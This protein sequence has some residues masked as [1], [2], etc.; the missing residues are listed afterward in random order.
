MNTPLRRFIGLLA[1]GALLTA[2][3]PAALAA[4][5][6]RAGPYRVELTTEPP[7]IPV[8][9]ARLTLKITD[10][11]GKPVEGAQVRA[12][13]QMPGMPMGEQ[14]G[15]A[16]PQP[17]Q[18]GVYSMAASFSM[19]GAYTATIKITGPQGPAVAQIPLKTGQNTAAPAGGGFSPIALLPWI[20]G[21]GAVGFILYRVW[22]TRPEGAGRPNWRA[23]FNRQVLGGLALVAVMLAGAFFA[24]RQ[25]RRPGS[26][27]P[28]EAQGME[29]STPAPPGT[30][31]VELATV[32]RGPVE[33]T[34]R[35]TGQ[36][37][38]F[39]EQDVTPRVRGYI[40]W[41][42]S[43]AGDRVKRGQVL[44]RLD[45]SEVAPVVAERQAGVAI[46]QQ[47]AGVA[48]TEYQQALGA[49]SQAKAELGTRQGALTETRSQETRTSGVLREAQTDLRTAEGALA[50]AQGD[51]AAAREERAGAE[52]DVAAAQTQVADAESQLQAAEAD[53]QYW[54]VQLG[55]TRVLLAEGAVSDEEYR[56]EK[57]QAENADAKVR[58]AQARISQVQSQVRGAQARLRKAG[59]MISSASAKERQANARIDGSRAR[60]EQAQAD[61]ASAAARIEQAQADLQAHHAH[62]RQAQSAANAARQRIGQAQSA[63]RQAQ[64]SL[65]GAA[66]A[67]GYTAVHS[68]L[69][70][71]VTQR[72]VS[73]GQLVNPGQTL[74]RVAQ[75]SPIRLQANVADADLG[76]VR[77]GTPVTIRKQA[78]G[79]SPVSARVTS[80][81]PAVDPAAR[82]GLVEAVVP[83]RDGRF[84]PGEYVVMD[85]ATGRS[86]S[87]LYVPAR[88]IRWRTAPSAGVLST[89]SSPYVWAA[90]S[91][92]GQQNQYTARQVDVRVGLS[93]GASTEVTSGLQAGQQVVINGQ[94]TLKNG[95]TVV[96]VN[97]E[98][99]RPRG[100]TGQ[101]PSPAPSAQLY[102]C[103]MHPEVVQDRPGNCPKCGMA[104][105][106]KPAP[107][108]GGTPSVPGSEP[109][110]APPAGTPPAGSGAGAAPGPITPGLPPAA[111][112][113]KMSAR[114]GMP[115]G[116][117]S[118]MAAGSGARTGGMTP[119]SA[120]GG[121][122]RRMPGAGATPG[123]SPRTGRSGMDGGE[124][125]GS[126]M[127]RSGARRGAAGMGSGSGADM[128]SGGGVP[129]LPPRG[130][131]PRTP[132]PGAMPAPRS[133]NAGPGP[134]GMDGSRPASPS[135]GRTAGGMTG[136]GR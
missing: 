81:A 58:Q 127:P 102:T 96:A 132:P 136:M 30:A 122:M 87:T 21:L 88:A 103:P 13:A 19:A 39:L 43:Y 108:G 90:E 124:A 35:Y 5:Q 78:G 46:A 57:A 125:S 112:R 84:V 48:R 133:T 64:A 77:V 126:G 70:G 128:P 98:A 71:V 12:I 6:A 49:V 50:E 55:R 52:A 29:M 74:L 83:N 47:G 109:G 95:D 123:M 118:G 115:V 73:P 86:A 67:E 119:G 66:T 28:I 53:R 60:I 63:V 61:I 24:V 44:A 89:Q 72:V 129:G 25:F 94:D 68:Q 107:S 20:A 7:V 26:M 117:E 97:A 130:G 4:V 135:K 121:G 2:P 113:P 93:N 104:L 120:P 131:V 101:P 79:Q 54:T 111:A 110:E 16:L 82:T 106:P 91:I 22:R 92:E 14:E 80:I 69:D 23:V 114:P 10:A 33:S 76:R 40:T 34:V 51:L 38:G 100:S 18:P 27:T 56:R 85:L 116:G 75:I 8:G 31:P 37:V 42:P 105:V 15:T 32:R 65:G 59:A 99:E 11:G 3:L 36:A 62:V 45:T 1:L 134:G 41:M 9:K 17:G